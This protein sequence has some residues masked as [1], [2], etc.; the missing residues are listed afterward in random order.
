MVLEDDMLSEINQTLKD[1]YLTYVITLTHGI[2]NN[3]TRSIGRE[4]DG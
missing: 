4:N 3:G 1:K 2:S